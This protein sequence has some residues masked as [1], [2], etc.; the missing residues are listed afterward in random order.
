MSIE[1]E[2]MQAS[3]QTGSRPRRLQMIVSVADNKDNIRRQTKADDTRIIGRRHQ[4]YWL[5]AKHIT[6]QCHRFETQLL[7][8][9]IL[10]LF[11][12][13]FRSFPFPHRLLDFRSTTSCDEFYWF[14]C[15]HVMYVWNFAK[16]L[17]AW[18]PYVYMCENRSWDFK[19]H[20]LFE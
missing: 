18:W 1:A 6:T 14:F 19:M 8:F 12:V 16:N 2:D 15:V 10:S 9:K 3:Q 5:Q 11:P 17:T 4:D 20:I 7:L 13:C